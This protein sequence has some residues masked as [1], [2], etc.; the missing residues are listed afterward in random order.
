MK[1]EDLLCRQKAEAPAHTHPDLHHHAV[2]LPGHPAGLRAQGR[3]VQD[4]PVQD[5]PVTD[6]LVQ[7]LQATDLPALPGILPQAGAAGHA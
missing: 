7:D 4:P 2:H 1:E 6:P 3:P 5:L